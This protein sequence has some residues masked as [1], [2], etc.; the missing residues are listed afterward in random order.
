MIETEKMSPH[1]ESELLSKLHDAIVKLNA[2]TEPADPPM[3]FY[4]SADRK[5]THVRMRCKSVLFSVSAAATITLT[6]GTENLTFYA[7]GATTQS[8]DLERIIERGIDVSIAAS[9][10]ALGT[11]WLVADVE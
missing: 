10:G 8:V 5:A 6:I 4:I 3:L 9:A 1:T 2:P 11:C 7:A